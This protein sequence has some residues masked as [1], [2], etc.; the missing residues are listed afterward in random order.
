MVNEQER[1]QEQQRHVLRVQRPMYNRSDEKQFPWPV[2]QLAIGDAAPNPFQNVTRTSAIRHV[3]SPARIFAL[4]S[5]ANAKSLPLLPE[6]LLMSGNYHR[7]RWSSM[8][9]RK[10][11]NVSVILDWQPFCEDEEAAAAEAEAEA[12]AEQKESKKN[13]E[14]TSISLSKQQMRRLRQSFAL[15]DVK[16]VGSLSKQY[17]LEFAAT[18]GPEYKASF[19]ARLAELSSSSDLIDFDTFVALQSGARCFSARGSRYFV[20]ITLAEAQSIRRALQRGQAL[21]GGDASGGALALRT[22]DGTVLNCSANWRA[23]PAYEQGLLFETCRFLNCAMYY[24]D[25]QLTSLLRALAPSPLASRRAFF[26]SV[27]LSRERQ[28]RTWL[29]TPLAKVFALDDEFHLLAQRALV[30]YVKRSMQL[31]GLSLLRAFEL[32]DADANGWLSTRELWSALHW[33]GLDA[34]QGTLS[35][36]DVEE[37]MGNVALA[38]SSSAAATAAKKDVPRTSSSSSESKSSS[39]SSSS[40]SSQGI[41]FA[42]FASLFFD[43]EDEQQGDAAAAAE[44]KNSSS[45]DASAVAGVKIPQLA[46]PSSKSSGSD[47]SGDD[48]DSDDDDDDY[49]DEDKK[50]KKK[51]DKKKK[52]H[53]SKA[54]K[55]KKKK[56]SKPRE[57]A[58]VWQCS[59]CTFASNSTDRTRCSMC[60]SNR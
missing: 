47:S 11:K 32:F 31:R 10:L 8:G 9:A 21:C 17:L 43:D 13:T 27:L 59:V 14:T 46:L 15:L 28:R 35:L 24:N 3:F 38:D 19:V 45:E 42:Q 26:Q 44:K 41:E 6:A 34:A 25:G 16:R 49:D 60:N 18:M 51:K 56:S 12:E 36:R 58:G 22:L 52:K 37:L 55:K 7:P 5:G 39:S 30:A 57:P 40:S 2:Q 20:I 23:G 50:K 53:K 29:A 4:G 33:L 48:D 1:E 54:S